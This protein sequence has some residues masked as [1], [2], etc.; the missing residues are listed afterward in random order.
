MDLSTAMGVQSLLAHWRAV[1]IA[2]DH[3]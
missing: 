2:A 1:E 3:A